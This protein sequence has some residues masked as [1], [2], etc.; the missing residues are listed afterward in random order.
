MQVRNVHRHTI[1]SPER[2]GGL[3]AGLGSD[4]DELWPGG[5]W[6]RMRLDG[7]LAVG[8]RGG[9]GPV[10]SSMCSRPACPASLN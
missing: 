9:H 3:L 1:G 6:P 8:A 7:P 2:L 10:R 5:R 4:T